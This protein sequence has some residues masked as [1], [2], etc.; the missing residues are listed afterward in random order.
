M[1]SDCLPHQVS[2]LA[3]HSWEKTLALLLRY[4]EAVPPEAVVTQ[5]DAAAAMEQASAASG[6]HDGAAPSPSGVAEGRLFEYL[7]A[8]FLHD[9]HLGAPFHGRQLVLYARHQPT[10][11]LPFLKVRGLPPEDRPCMQG[12]ITALSTPLVPGL[13]TLP[14]RGRVR[15]VSAAPADRRA[16]VRA[17]SLGR[18]RRGTPAHARVLAGGLARGD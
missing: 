8:L 2:Q 17:R 5:L 6:A 4:V 18:S 3:S 10:L 1:S 7:H 9:V 15:R 14:T 16:G 11:L 12:L 13:A